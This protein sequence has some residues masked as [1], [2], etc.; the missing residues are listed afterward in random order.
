M[1]VPE[2]AGR[3]GITAFVGAVLV[4][5]FA[6]LS[7]T[8]P[9][10][11]NGLAIQV[12]LQGALGV[13]TAEYIIGGLEEAAQRDA[14]LVIIRI[15]TP[16]GLVEPMRDIVQAILA[17]PVPVATYV[18]P[19]GARADSAGT[20]I[21]LASHIAAMAPTTHIGAA[22]PVSLGGEDPPERPTPFDRPSPGDEEPES[23]EPDAIDRSSGDTAMERK[24]M[25]DA[26]AYIRGLAET[27]GRN[28]E[29]AESAVRDAA[30]LT[31]NQA[32]EQNVVDLI[33]VDRGELLAAIHG[34]EVNLN[35]VPTVI[36]TE[37]LQVEVLEPSWRIKLLSTIASPEIALL[38]VLVGIYGLIFEGYNPGAIVPGVVGVIAL[39]LAAYALQVIPVNYA[40]LALII[41]GIAMIVAEAFLPSFGAL[42]LGGIA[43]FVFGAI[44]MFDTGVPGFGISIAFVVTLAVVAGVFLF[45]LV[46]YLLRLQRRGAVSGRGSIVGGT[47]TAMQNFTGPGRVWLEGE[48]WQAFSDAP[49]VKG[50][51]V[52]VRDLDGLIIIVEPLPDSRPTHAEMQT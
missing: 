39:L 37:N 9:A 26:I 21:L 18:S 28:A 52:L 20:Y 42:G 51:S 19:G 11:A 33:A 38:L 8:A 3:G 35:N 30:T 49:V 15:D 13:A 25:N 29:W 45:L 40:G 50:Q 1:S 27:H 44:M 17:S 12:D 6:A 41:V 36:D 46:T 10:R 34:R 5:V 4:T 48:A 43:A 24:V 7:G 14:S 32:L 47:G 22:T 2:R 23:D 31:A 16:G